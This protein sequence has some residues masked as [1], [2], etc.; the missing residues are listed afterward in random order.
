LGDLLLTR[1]SFAPAET[2]FKKVAAAPWPET[3]TRADLGIARARLG[4]GQADAALQ[5]LDAIAQRP[6]DSDDAK[7]QR[8]VATILKARCQAEL[9]KVDK[10]VETLIDVIA[11]TDPEDGPLQAHA[12]N[13]LGNCYLKKGD[14]GTKDALLAFL[15][16]DILYNSVPER[17][18]EAL[19]RLIPLWE[20]I[21]KP[22]RAS[23]ARA[24]LRERYPQSRWAR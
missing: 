13:T 14:A 23:E 16:V 20:A 18:A 21:G 6:A 10:G 11:K 19:A 8:L 22:K 24:L 4:Q 12:Y 15:H 3:Q 9:G 5:Q 7:K 17:H 1:G 2:Y